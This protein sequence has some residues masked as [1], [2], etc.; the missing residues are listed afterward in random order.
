MRRARGP[1]DPASL[2]EVEV[3][4]GDLEL[5][6]EEVAVEAS[7]GVGVGAPTGETVAF[8]TGY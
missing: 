7:A 3:E 1:F 5:E 8:G 2:I 4:S 6:E